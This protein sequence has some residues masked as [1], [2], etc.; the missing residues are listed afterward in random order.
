MDYFMK[1]MNGMEAAEQILRH[2]PRIKIFIATGED[3]IEN[4]VR[5]AGLGYL[6]KPL[7]IQDLMNCME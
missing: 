5:S 4:R 6:K 7:R 1:D 2:N 3:E